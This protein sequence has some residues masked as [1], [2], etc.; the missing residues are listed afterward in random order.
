MAGGLVAPEVPAV[1]V[2]LP[3]AED[4][5]LGRGHAP[6]QGR[7][8][9]EQLEGGTRRVDALDGPVQHGPGG[10]VQVAVHHLLA[11][12][13]EE[14]VRIIGGA[15]VHRQ[16]AAVAQV[17]H[18][19]GAGLLSVGVLHHLL[20]ARI[21]GQ[22]EAAAR[23]GVGL[24]E[25]GDLGAQ[26]VHQDALLAI[27]ALELVVAAGLEALLADGLAQV[28][29]IGLGLHQRLVHLAHVAE[30]M[31]GQFVTEVDAPWR[32]IHAEEGKAGPDPLGQRDARIVQVLLQHQGPALPGQAVTLDLPR[33]PC[34]VQLQG[35][36]QGLDH[37]RVRGEVLTLD[38]E[39]QG[40]TVVH[41]PV[42]VAVQ[43]QAA[44]RGDG[45]HL[46]RLLHGQLLELAVPDDLEPGVD[47][48]QQGHKAPGQALEHPEAA[49]EEGALP[50][51]H[52][53]SRG[54]GPVYIR[55]QVAQPHRGRLSRAQNQP[56]PQAWGPAPR[57][58]A[59]WTSSVCANRNPAR[60]A[61][62]PFSP[63]SGQRPAIQPAR[64]VRVMS[65]QAV[66]PRCG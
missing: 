13:V 46:H 53:P 64:S 5:R 40:A 21:Q 25:V 15:G 63:S 20:Q 45:A 26:L 56:E 62:Q 2:L 54:E 31:A 24:P 10:V 58:T 59:R 19:R 49:V 51:I 29:D 65:A 28:V 17:D 27:H 50:G 55:R 7:Q 44:R 35:L 33:Q 16:D 37:R 36:G 4:H 18:H 43:H 34:R 14:E 8:G 57:R 23:D 41:Q 61:S 3:A 42:A 30:H 32:H 60:R 1:E 6:L 48:H 22:V 52:Q 39:V 12:A 11:E 38:D 9:D 66:P 47:Q